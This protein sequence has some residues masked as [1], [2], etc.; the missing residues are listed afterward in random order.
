M[1]AHEDSREL[2]ALEAE[3]GQAAAEL[4]KAC[5]A[6][7]ARLRPFFTV[8]GPGVQA[9]L[10]C[11]SR[12]GEQI[13]AEA[14]AMRRAGAPW[15]ASLLDVNLAATGPRVTHA[16]PGLSWHQ[17][18]EAIDC[19]VV[20]ANNQA[21]WTPSHPHYRIYA[22]EAS[23]LGLEAGAF[24]VKFSDAVHVQKRKGANPLRAGWTWPRIEEEMKRR[25][26][27]AL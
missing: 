8:R 7:G 6:K 24:W 18:G 13:A 19:F 5:E 3:F 16:L 22:T 25:F 12:S 4:L 15:L 9:R 1:K 27:G 11:Q 21:I 2:S 10:W 26:G 14:S 20:G 23:R 17:W